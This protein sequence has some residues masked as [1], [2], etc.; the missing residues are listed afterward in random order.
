MISFFID[1]VSAPSVFRLIW[2]AIEAQFLNIRDS[3]RD[4]ETAAESENS[5]CLI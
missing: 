5:N 1:Y 2:F 3:L 4:A